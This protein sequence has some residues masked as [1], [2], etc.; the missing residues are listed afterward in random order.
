[1]PCASRRIMRNLLL[2]I[3]LF[4]VC[5]F[6]AE[7]D[8]LIKVGTPV[9]LG[10]YSATLTK[11]DALPYIDNEYSRRFHFDSFDNPKLKE[12]RERYK[13]DEVIA[14][15]KT[16]IEK[17]ALLMNWAHHQFK[18]FGKPSTNSKGALDVLRDVEN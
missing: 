2:S 18:K 12:L 4:V 1:M 8:S 3:S 7:S 5:A 17:Q 16:E 9:Q 13:L 6:A 14:S 10:A 15:G 11:L